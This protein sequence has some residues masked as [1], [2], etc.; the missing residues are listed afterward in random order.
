MVTSAIDSGRRILADA[1]RMRYPERAPERSVPGAVVYAGLLLHTLLSAGTYLFA[2]HALTEMPPLP[3]G[4]VRFAGASI[5][6]VALL[7]RVRPKGQR[8]PPRRAV[9]KLL[10]LALVGVPINQGFFLVGLSL[11]TAS[12]AALIYTLTPLFVLLLAQALS[13]EAP[14]ARTAIGTVLAL[15]GTLYVLLSRGMAHGGALAGDLLLLVAVVAWAFYTAEGRE[16]VAEHGPIATTAWTLIGGTALYL[17]I[18]AASLFAPG[19]ADQLT[20]VSAQGWL[21]IAYLIVVTSVVSYLLWYWAL[22]HLPAAR[23]AVFNNLQPLATA[24]LAQAVLHER[25][26]LSFF[27]GAAVVIFG[28]VLA[29]SGG[30]GPPATPPEPA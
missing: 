14:G 10:L 19:A 29:Q 26:T 3:L 4:L 15:G 16:L 28:V 21:G 5:C 8:L 22:A 9:R 24:L 27:A 13:R 23:V 2:K 6:L 7:M 25:A 12:H 11:S 1:H 30:R 17:P 18:G 20:R